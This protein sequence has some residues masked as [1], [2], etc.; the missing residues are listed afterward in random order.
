MIHP[1]KGEAAS[2]LD[3]KFYPLLFRLDQ[4]A[5]WLIWFAADVDGV[6]VE[7]DGTVP[8]F[9]SLIDLIKFANDRG[10]SINDGVD[11]ELHDIDAVDAWLINHGAAIDCDMFL[12]VWNLFKDVAVSVGTTLNDQDLNTREVY[13][14]LFR[15]NNLPAVI[16][17]GCRYEPS[18]TTTDLERL[19]QVLS[20]GIGL[21]RSRTGDE[22]IRNLTP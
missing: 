7:S 17:E 15:G 9:D 16:A 2:E 21:F 6:W 11:A 14:K 8:T 4:K 1:P 18:W 5:R 22:P 10:I 20:R 13:Q 12:S 19:S 3:G